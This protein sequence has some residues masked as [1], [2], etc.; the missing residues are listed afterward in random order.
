MKNDS[1]RPAVLD[2]FRERYSLPVL[3]RDALAGLIVGIIAIP[4]SI[5]F[6]IASGVSPAH[7]LIT[8]FV[9][10]LVIAVFSGS[11]VQIG[12]PT[13]A[14]IVILYGV[15]QKFGVDGLMLASVM[16]GIMLIVMALARLGDVIK[17]I[18]YPVTIGFTSGIAL[19]I[20]STQIPDAL[21]LRI[22]HL[23][24]H[25]LPKLATY[26]AALPTLNPWSAAIAVFTVTLI[27][28][29]PR[30]TARV[31]AALVAIILTSLAVRLFQLPVETIGSRFTDISG[32][33]SLPRLPAVSLS[34]ITELL[35]AAFSIA[36]LAG[37]ESLL[38]AVVADGMT[39]RRHR[40]NAELLAQ[41]LANIASPLLGG[42]PVTGAIARTAANIKNGGS[43]PVAGIVHAFT[44]LLIFLFFGRWTA[45]IPMSAL[46][47]ILIVVAWNMSE[48]HLFLKLFRSTRSDVMVLLTTFGLT[49]L[50]DLTVAIE[51]G[52]VLA[53][54][55]F[56]RRLIIAAEATEITDALTN[57][58]YD[59][60]D[61]ESL[62]R[63]AIP[64]GVE[65]YEIN[66]PFF[67]GAAEKFKS[68]LREISSRPRVIIFRMRHVP[69]V[70]ATGLRALEEIIVRHHSLR[71]AVILS[72][73]RGS[74]RRTLENAGIAE[75]L[76]AE[77]ITDNIDQ[78]L[79]RANRIL[80]P[81]WHEQR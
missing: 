40:S 17:Y 12:G 32:S 67:F 33:I 5:A 61:P 66:G 41:G 13:G 52:I 20:F 48:T 80:D 29:W 24:E 76:G 44:V 79:V 6:A 65:V 62:S 18:P 3:F 35:P 15:V 34:R 4:L 54:F 51:V 72:G 58:D 2:M 31:P 16:A 27:L 69:V 7:G 22:E 28:L 43:T 9:G 70:D 46:A 45:L 71:S 81:V 26:G 37:I 23:P 30:L 55:L 73:V 78:A 63:K 53:A 60:D 19:V 75:R 1:L 42:I 59:P 49:V 64:L 50:V 77:N 11:R 25:F 36:M 39:G 14:F 21:G 56:M 10:G 74:I 57:G 68:A 8:A 47:G 38:S